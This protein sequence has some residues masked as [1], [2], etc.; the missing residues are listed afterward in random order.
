M[1]HLRAPLRSGAGRLASAS[2]L[3]LAALLTACG[4]VSGGSSGGG[5]TQAAPTV[6]LT[7]NPTALTGTGTTSLTWST[8]NAT[9]CTASDGWTGSQTTAG[10][11]TSAT[12][13]A[14]TTF[15]LSCSGPGGNASSSAT[16]TVTAV[17]NVALTGQITFDRVP[18][19]TT[20][21]NGLDFT[22]VTQ[23]PAR[24]VVVEA[25]AA[26]SGSVLASG[27]TDANG[28]YSLN[29][30][31][32]TSLFVRAKAQMLRTGTPAWNFSVR[33]NT[34][35]DALYVLDGSSFNSG[36]S[37]SVRNLNAS[38]GFVGS[39]YTGTRAAAPFAILD[40]VYQAYNL[41][42]SADASTVFPTLQLEWSVRNVPTGTPTNAELALGQISTTFFRTASTPNPA[43][44]YI[45]GA[46]DN[47]TD[48][49]DAAVIA[50]EWGHYY[51]DSFSRDDSIGGNHRI[52]E[53]LDPRLAFSE[54]WGNAFSG[55]V[56]GDPVYR[57]S[58]GNTEHSDF[59]INVETPASSNVGW[60]SED[61]VQAV[62]WD[63]F[64][65]AADANDAVSLGFAP[66]HAA[67]SGPV[68]NNSALTTI[69]PLMRAL[70]ASNSAQSA[71]L[72]QLVTA[73]N[74]IVPT[75]D[76]GTG[77]SN[78]GSDARNLPIYA[79]LSAGAPLANVC[80]TTTAG[81]T[82]HL[83]NRKL[84]R[85]DVSGTRNAT[86]TATGPTTPTASD[87]DM[88]LYAAGVQRA[89]AESTTAGSETLTATS[90]PTGTY[91]LELYEYSNVAGGTARGDTCFTVQLTLN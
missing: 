39:A 73:Q 51:Q 66:I 76:F 19:N 7:A 50:H 22:R 6:T 61:S 40:T 29:V 36:T 45:L 33:D 67:M 10:S 41:V 35:S 38:S 72:G 42:L 46:A 80:S 9:S 43:R 34:A 69:Y 82:N 87:P 63:V 4:G 86:I 83:G 75:D 55:M 1:D 49:Y 54:G 12:L 32:N 88:V 77:E 3:A 81:T 8:A 85:F 62:I 14:T 70:I 24:G 26:G 2:G 15:T 18:F 17:A 16:V 64:D 23:A 37:A 21:A 20:P 78:S 57:D 28:Q 47:D 60:Y 56:R 13:T 74:M 65:S 31:G 44:I 30:P 58:F 11:A 68:R 53:K 79:V 59:S 52:S 91:V 89:R 71:A 25:I 48:E 90:L 5:G 27:V 84:L